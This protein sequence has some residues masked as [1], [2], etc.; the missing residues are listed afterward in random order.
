MC[1]L[2]CVLGLAAS[3]ASAQATAALPSAAHAQ[4]AQLVSDAV[5]EYNGGAW[6]EA[7]LLFERAHA[8][9]PNARTLRGL[10]LCAFELAR[11]VD[12]VA[13]FE[14]ALADPRQPLLPEQRIEVAAA[15]ARARRYVGSVRVALVPAQATLLIDGRIARERELRL[16]VGDYRLSAKAPGYEPKT[17]ALNVEGGQTQELR[18][19]LE[20]VGR[21][22]GADAGS[23]QRLLGWTALGAAGA[24]LAVGLAFELQRASTLDER[25]AICPTNVDCEP[26]AQRRVDR[27][28]DEARTS[29]TIEV[30]GFVAGA[31]LLA[32]GLTL[33]LTAP[34]KAAISRSAMPR[35][36]MH[37]TGVALTG[38]L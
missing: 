20:P 38:Q 7:R 28:S 36:G 27:L 5:R 14:A 11:Y 9:V 8:L 6:A 1:S 13:E 17:L 21:D 34:E 10:G 23:T 12:A 29:A 25:D 32:S 30:V 22:S 18:L 37:G 24:A 3:S 4:Y 35:L 15:L 26:G 16:N 31:A 2:S 19:A 33:L